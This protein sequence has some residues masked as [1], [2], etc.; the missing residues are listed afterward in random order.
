MGTRAHTVT[1]LVRPSDTGAAAKG[2]Q[3]RPSSARSVRVGPPGNGVLPAILGLTLAAIAALFVVPSAR[4]LFELAPLNPG[5]WILG[6]GA[7]TLANRIVVGAAEGAA[8]R[9]PVRLMSRAGPAIR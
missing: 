1:P 7:G 3:P 6:V 2:D 4:D 8:R 9:G 5:G